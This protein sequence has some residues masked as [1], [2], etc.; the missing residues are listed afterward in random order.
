MYKVEK[1][2]N[3]YSGYYTIWKRY[4]YQMILCTKTYISAGG[5]NQAVVCLPI[6]EEYL[7]NIYSDR[8]SIIVQYDTNSEILTNKIMKE[9]TN[10]GR[11]EM[12]KARG[13][14]SLSRSLFASDVATILAWYDAPKTDLTEEMI[15]Y[16]K[17]SFPGIPIGP[18]Y[19]QLGVSSVYGDVVDF[20]L[21]G[22]LPASET[23]P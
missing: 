10:L 19:I 13:L 2:V 5:N 1:Y 6:S 15:A 12:L 8:T 11:R 7:K 14:S 17:Y 4:T 16:L 20:S 21:F 9:V 18:G 23:L 3:S 22:Y